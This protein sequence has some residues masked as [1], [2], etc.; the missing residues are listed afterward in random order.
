MVREDN[1]KPMLFPSILGCV[2]LQVSR[3]IMNEKIHAINGFETQVVAYGDT[4][5]LYIPASAYN[6]LDSLGLIGEDLF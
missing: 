4:D 1:N 5:S 6:K 2:I 3:Q